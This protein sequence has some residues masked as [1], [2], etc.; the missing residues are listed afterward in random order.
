MDGAVYGYLSQSARISDQPASVI[1]RCWPHVDRM[2]LFWRAQ[3]PCAL[4]HA[5]EHLGVAL[6]DDSQISSTGG[7]LRRTYKA[8][9]ERCNSQ[10]RDLVDGGSCQ[11]QG[12]WR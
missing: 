4:R 1:W 9:A 11:A 8:L 10:C 2:I 7:S 3:V 6:L 5:A 12:A